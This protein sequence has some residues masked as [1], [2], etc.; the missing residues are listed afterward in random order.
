[1]KIKPLVSVIVVTYNS[2][3][4][5]LETLESIKRQTYRNLELVV[6]DDCSTDR[7]V[8]LVEEWVKENAARFS[9]VRIVTSRV[10]TGITPN[11][12]R[13]ILAASGEYIKLIAG[14]DILIETCIE[15]MVGFCTSNNLEFA[16]ARVTTFTNAKEEA[17]LDRSRILSENLN[18]EIFDFTREKQ[19]R[20]ILSGFRMY[21]LGLFMRKDFITR[22]GLF[23]EKY[24]MMEDYPF[25]L[26]A[27]SKG[28]KLELLNEVLAKYRVRSPAET[29]RILNTRRKSE[30]TSDLERF[31]KEELIPRMKK[32]K[33]YIALYNTYVR[34]L[35]RRIVNSSDNILLQRFGKLVGY[36]SVSKII[37][38]AKMIWFRFT[39]IPSE[40]R[41]SQQM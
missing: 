37:G 17:S 24:R 26:K 5:V 34:R 12:N 1:M 27:V 9:R 38:R 36:L 13:G 15:K 25:V 18:H 32:E 31:E 16:Y 11:I 14:D 41:H 35:E 30:H 28:Y 21:A 8:S 3:A 2:E 39:L 6:T 29:K 23:N 20:R 4:F 10:N 22:M 40:N 19:Y 7:T 33:M